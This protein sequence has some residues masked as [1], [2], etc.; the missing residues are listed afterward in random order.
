MT[1]AVYP[2]SFDPAT[3][4]H[5]DIATRAAAI[6]DRVIVAIYD[7]PAKNLLFTTEERVDMMAKALAGLPNVAV[8]SFSGLVVD[9]ARRSGAKVIVRGL[10]ASADFEYEFEMALMNRKLAP[11]IEVVCLMTSVEYL[12]LSASLLKEV[13][14]LGGSIHNMVPDHVASALRKKFLR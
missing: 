7:R 2:G 6:F 9:L 12:F 14:V 13:A 10:R 4:G 8:H 3:N 5:I 11:E 1:V